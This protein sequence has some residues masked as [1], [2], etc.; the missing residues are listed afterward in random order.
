VG[1]WRFNSESGENHSFFRDWSKRGNNVKCW[2]ENCPAATSGKFG[3]ALGF[4]GVN[5]YVDAGNRAI[6]NIK[7]AI[8]IEAWINP[9]VAQEKCH[10]EVSGN[11]GVMSKVGGPTNSTNWS[12][13]L[14]YGAPGG[15]CYLGFNFNGDPEGSRWVTVKQNLTPGKWYHIAG[16]FNG[17]DLYFYLNGKLTETNKISAIK[18]Y[19]NQLIIGND[20]WANGFN[21]KIDEVRIHKRA[22]SPEEIKA[23]YN[24]G[25]YRLYRNFTD[26][27]IGSYNYQA[28]SQ[29]LQGNMNQTEKRT[30]RRI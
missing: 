29:N 25:I 21:G 13:Q 22:L 1:W 23:S 27:A 28:Y 10:D 6:L 19:R 15:G 24:A 12:W 30:F 11:F 4:D 17:T 3:N 20:G 14:R 26:L 16:T 8:T 7:G 5:D 9:E 2:G 18:K